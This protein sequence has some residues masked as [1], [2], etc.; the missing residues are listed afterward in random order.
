MGERART[1]LYFEPE[2]DDPTDS[3]FELVRADARPQPSEDTLP[4]VVCLDCVLDEWRGIG[5]GLDLAREHGEAELVSGEWRAT[6]R[7]FGVTGARIRWGSG[8]AD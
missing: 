5:P 3:G 1:V 7:V 6:T 4:E 2:P 8:A